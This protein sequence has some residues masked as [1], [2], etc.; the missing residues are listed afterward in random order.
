[1][2]DMYYD[3]IIKDAYDEI[4]YDE[5]YDVH[6]DAYD[7]WYD[8]RSDAYDIWYDTRSDIYDFQYDLRSEV[9][10]QDDERAQKKMDKFKKS[11]LRMKE[12]VND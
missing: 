8:A 11:I 2:Y 9:Y 12:D 4:D 6:S 3:G 1:M 10:D 7:D 5:W